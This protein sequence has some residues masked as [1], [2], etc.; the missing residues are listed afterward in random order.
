MARTGSRGKRWAIT[1]LAGERPAFQRPPYVDAVL[2]LDDLRPA[3]VYAARVAR[4][5][6][7]PGREEAHLPG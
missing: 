7:V 1:F 2:A 3:A 6:E 5:L 4:S